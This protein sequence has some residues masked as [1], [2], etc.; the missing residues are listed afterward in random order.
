[1]QARIQQIKD[2]L[3]IINKEI[4]KRVDYRYEWNRDQANIDC[5]NWDYERK[6]LEM[7]LTLL[8]DKLP[9]AQPYDFWP[10]KWTTTQTSKL[11]SYWMINHNNDWNNW[12][13]VQGMNNDTLIRNL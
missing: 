5:Y 8:Q 11:P 4:N 9:P 12:E 2:R 7:E 3:F 10:R 13:M 6:Y 1:M